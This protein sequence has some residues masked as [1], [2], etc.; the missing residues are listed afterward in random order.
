MR[1]I[2][3]VFLAIGAFAAAHMF[4]GGGTALAFTQMTSPFGPD[5]PVGATIG[6]NNQGTAQMIVWQRL[7]DGVCAF[8]PIGDAAGLFDD[9]GVVGSSGND[10]IMIAPT[11][12][13]RCGAPMGALV[14]GGHYLDLYGGAGNDVLV[15]DTGDTWLFGQDGNDHL[16]FHGNGNLYGGS[17]IDHLFALTTFFSGEGLFGEAGGDCLEDGNG[18]AA[19]VDCGSGAFDLV[20]THFGVPMSV[21]CEFSTPSNCPY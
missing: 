2:A 12:S 18:A 5:A 3:K 7:S 14:Y 17:G 16:E 20:S 19:A 13:G 8:T 11:S 6:S 4:A 9:Y 15:S 1:N 21:N 10:E